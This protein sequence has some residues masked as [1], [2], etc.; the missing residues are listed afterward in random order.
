MPLNLVSAFLL[1]YDSPIFKRPSIRFDTV[2]THATGSEAGLPGGLQW[3]EVF[4]AAADQCRM[5][6]KYTTH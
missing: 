5:T 4:A 2:T 3:L 6:L 1:V